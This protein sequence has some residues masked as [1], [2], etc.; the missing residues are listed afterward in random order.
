MSTDYEKAVLLL[1]GLFARSAASP[2]APKPQRCQG[3]LRTAVH[4]LV[5]CAGLAAALI[6]SA[7][8]GQQAAA[9][10]LPISYATQTPTPFQAH[11]PT[12][13]LDPTPTSTPVPTSTVTPTSTLPPTSTPF[14]CQE[15]R[16]TV[17]QHEIQVET[18]SVI[19]RVYLPPCYGVESG[20]RY[21]VL[22]MIHGQTYKDDQWDRL[23]IDEAADSLIASGQA[24]PFLIVMPLEKNTFE[25]IFLSPFPGDFIDGLI[26]WI[27]SN[28]GT[29][30]D[31]NCRAIGGL[32]RGGAWAFRLGFIH[33]QLFGAVGLHSTPPFIG[34][35]NRLPGWL[36]Q[37]PSDQIPRLYMDTGRNDYFIAP[38]TQLE[39]IL[40]RL[41]LAHEWYLFNG[42]HNEEYWSEHVGDYLQ[43]YTQP[44]Q[45][46]SP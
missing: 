6:L 44:W 33:W 34:D 31:R 28:Y 9:V 46:T 38:T 24:S 2:D 17:E 32:S 35:P 20:R 36:Q 4:F 10:L 16:G 23:G 18:R 3:I 1:K 45:E 40:V 37:I 12:P 43:W 27:D 13:T 19:F 26:P 11:S 42:T 8:Q 25:D 15:D 22:Y 5:L 39:E 29:C 21:P 7:C 14:I 30:T 41:G